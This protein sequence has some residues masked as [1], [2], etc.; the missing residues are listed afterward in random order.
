MRISAPP[1]LYPCFFGTD[2]PDSEALIA[3]NR[4]VEEI[5]EMIGVDSLGFLSLEATNR[6]AVGAHC[7][8]CDACFSGNYP[9]A[10]PEKTEN[11]IFEQGL[12]H[13]E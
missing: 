3:H 4:S 6:I 1:F 11:N 12:S 2:I 10:V 7:T 13:N 5:R 9:V 8:F